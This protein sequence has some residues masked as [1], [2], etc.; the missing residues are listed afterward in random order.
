MENPFKEIIHHEKLPDTLK[1]K[2]ISDVESIKLFLD[3]ADLT[4][5]KYPSLMENLYKLLKS[6]K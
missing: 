6:K 1:E 4:M 5:V 2:V 3:M